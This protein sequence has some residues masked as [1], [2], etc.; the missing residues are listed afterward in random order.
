MN[1]AQTSHLAYEPHIPDAPLAQLDRALPS[2]GRG[3]RFESSRDRHFKKTFKNLS[4]PLVRQSVLSCV[5]GSPL[6]AGQWVLGSDQ[7]ALL[8]QGDVAF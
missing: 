2:E 5:D 7:L 1:I 4:S 6:I 3:Q 8:E